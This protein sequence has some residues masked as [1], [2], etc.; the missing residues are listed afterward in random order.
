M[1]IV[2]LAYDSGK[3]RSTARTL[4]QIC[5]IFWGNVRRSVAAVM[6]AVG[7]ILGGI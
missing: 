5:L 4:A 7:T 1:K 2:G 3:S 6:A